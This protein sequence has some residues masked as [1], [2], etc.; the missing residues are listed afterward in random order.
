MFEPRQEDGN[1]TWHRHS[2]EV[3]L[4]EGDWLLLSRTTRGAQQIEEEVRRRGH[5][6]IYNGSKSIDGKVLEAVRLWEYLREGNMI[7]KDQVLLVYKH[8]M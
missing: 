1:I 2:E 7:C 3:S 5:L 8:M 6:Y 4:S